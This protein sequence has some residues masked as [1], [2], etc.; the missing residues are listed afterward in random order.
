MAQAKRFI[1]VLCTLGP[2]SL[3]R[4][5]IQRL[6]ERGVDLFRINLSHT[7]LEKV[8]ETIEIIQVGLVRADVLGHRRGSG[9][10]GR[11]AER[12][13]FPKRSTCG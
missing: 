3:N 6:E 12:V 11:M 8:A 7:P 1:K 4:S 9:S 2:A 13:S 5:V 10:H